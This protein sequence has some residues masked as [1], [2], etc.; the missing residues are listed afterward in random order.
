MTPPRRV[1]LV[2]AALIVLTLGPALGARGPASAAEPLGVSALR[3]ADAS[4]GKWRWPLHGP[5]SVAAPYRAPAHE[6]G[7][8]HRGID[9]A[10]APGQQLH[11]PAEGVVAFR[12][13]VVDRPLLTLDHGAGYVST[14]EPL[15]SAL[16]PGDTV[17]AG[18]VIGVV[19][20]GG[21]SA[22][23]TVHV[24]VRLDGVYIDPL[25][26]FDSP[27]RAVLLPCCA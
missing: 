8:G 23:G 17:A 26:L 22:H 3:A 27:P 18:D 15:D 2:A 13:T 19:A 14:Y 10:A 1:R 4:D 16:S 11:A 6:Y 25:L 20:Q 12:G 5:R 24:G 9:I 7:A 21:H